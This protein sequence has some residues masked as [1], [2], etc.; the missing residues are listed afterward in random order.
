M[1]TKLTIGVVLGAVLVFCARRR[2]SR[3]ELVLYAIGLV[4]AAVIYVGFAFV[5]AA[6]PR[7]TALEVAGLLPFLGF[8]WLGLRR[9][10]LWLAVGWVA[11]AIWD[12]GLHLLAGTPT[13]VPRSYPVFCVGFDLIVAA[14]IILRVRGKAPASEAA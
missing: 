7:W 14:A 10:P 5:G 4:V 13:F 1:V 3:G 12:V 8:T 6:G 2:G 11:H 9:A